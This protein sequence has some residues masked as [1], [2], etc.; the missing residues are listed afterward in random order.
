MLQAADLLD[1]R[2][3]PYRRDNI[4]RFCLTC[5][6]PAFQSARV[7]TNCAARSR[8]RRSAGSEVARDK[9]WFVEQPRRCKQSARSRAVYRLVIPVCV[10]P[11]LQ[12]WRSAAAQS[13]AR[14]SNILQLTSVNSLAIFSVERRVPVACSSCPVSRPP[15]HSLFHAAH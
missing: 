12:V 4:N 13:R 6:G 5:A 14:R 15:C 2:P 10:T 1:Q 11:L 8:G 3:S 9:W 7:P